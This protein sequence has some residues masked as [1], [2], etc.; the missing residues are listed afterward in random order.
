M[1]IIEE[2]KEFALKGNAMDLAI[3]VVIGAAFNEIVTS[4]VKDIITPSLGLIGGQPDFSSVGFFKAYNAA[5]EVTGGIMVGNF[6]N[7]LISFLIVGFSLFVAVKGINT[8][9][10]V[11]LKK[12][13]TNS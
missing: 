13:N 5:G 7:A 3:G 9:K 8:L 1:K 10:K 6:L 12:E 2:F 11:G 4:L